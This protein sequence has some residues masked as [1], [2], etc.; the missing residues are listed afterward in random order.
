M[1]IITVSKDEGH[2]YTVTYK[3]VQYLS[4]T[5]KRKLFYSRESSQNWYWLDTGRYVGKRLC[6][7]MCGIRM[8]NHDFVEV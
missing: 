5:I 4:P 6:R 1:R 3:K 8:G 7:I 2:I